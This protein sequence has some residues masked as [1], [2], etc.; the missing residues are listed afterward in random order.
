MRSRLWRRPGTLALLA[1]LI[2]PLGVLGPAQAGSSGPQVVPAA[3]VGVSQ[4]LGTLDPIAPSPSA[5]G[6]LRSMRPRLV[7]P[8]SQNALTSG[9][10]DASIVQNVPVSNAMPA[11]V[12][13]F[14]GVGNVSGI[15]PPDTQGDMGW[16][17]ATGTKYYV[18]WV[19]L[20]FEIWDVTNP[21]A[22]VSLYGPAAGNTLWTGTG[23]VCEANNDGD[24]ITQF[25]HLANRW[26]MSQFALPGFPNDFHQ[27]IAVSATAD[28]T[29]DWYLYDFKTSDTLMNDYPHFGV[30]SDGY[31]M[32]VNQLRRATCSSGWCGAGVAVFERDCHAAGPARPHD[33]H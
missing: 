30:W 2:G 25:D 15:L 10:F 22:P 4:P 28:P 19:N 9:G 27:C 16:D 24:P 5:P 3:Y 17:P 6:I 23:G 26:M 32:T 12:A 18:Q 11:A 14:E 31:Y 33:L 7:I 29:G 1:L 20:A 8:K 21:A 13:N